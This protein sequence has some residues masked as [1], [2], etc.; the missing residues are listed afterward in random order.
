MVMEAGL[1]VS[2]YSIRQ[3][4]TNCG[5]SSWRTVHAGGVK[6]TSA[7]MIVTPQEY[8]MDLRNYYAEATVAAV[9]QCNVFTCVVTWHVWS[10]AGQSIACNVQLV[11][12]YNENR[13]LLLS[14]VLKHICSNKSKLGLG[15]YLSS[16]VLTCHVHHSGFGPL[17]YN[18][19][20]G[21]RV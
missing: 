6:S 9:T 18:I 2:Q 17:R 15:V 10:C 1:I 13:W 21:L 4:N 5:S 16:R 7:S 3:L 14:I 12:H 8:I 11:K 20:V 19:T